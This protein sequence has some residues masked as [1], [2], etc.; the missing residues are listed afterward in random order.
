MI[1]VQNTPRMAREAL[2]KQAPQPSAT[3]TE[4]DHVGSMQE[5]LACGFTPQTRAQGLNI[6]QDGHQTAVLESHDDLPQPCAM[7]AQAG[8][9]A[10]FDFAPS[11]FP[12]GCTSFGPKR[13]HH[14]VSSQGQGQGRHLS[15]QRLARRHMP[16]GHSIQFLLEALH[17]AAASRLDPAPHRPRA[18]HAA[19]VPAQQPRRRGK[20]DKDGESTAQ[21]LEFTAGSLMRL[22]PQGLIEGGHLRDGA[23]L[24]TPSDAS[25]PSERS[26]QAGELTLGKAFAAQRGPT[27]RARGPGYRSLGTF[28]QHIFDD[29]SGQ[30]TR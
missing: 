14:A 10:D 2:L 18:H 29:V 22:H 7:L 23:P 3:V 5:T 19:T 12:R 17:G 24:G 28:G 8:Q 16:P 4:P 6:P 30:D 20:G 13:H 15:R 21:K 1:K 11:A 25:S 27:G 9:H 26:Q